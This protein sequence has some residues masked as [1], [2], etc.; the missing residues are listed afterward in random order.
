MVC[1]ESLLSSFLEIELIREMILTNKYQVLTICLAFC[2]GRKGQED[3]AE[4]YVLVDTIRLM[5]SR[6]S[7]IKCPRVTSPRPGEQRAGITGSGTRQSERRLALL[8][9][10][11]G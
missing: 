2:Q 4:A 6:A 10:P 8:V 7:V 5:L 11:T 3:P 1:L 9:W